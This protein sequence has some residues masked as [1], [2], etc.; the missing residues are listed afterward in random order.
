MSDADRKRPPI[1]RRFETPFRWEGVERQR[2][3]EGNSSFRDVSR[4]V[5]FN[6]E[7]G[8]ASQLRYFEIAP[9]GHTTLERHRHPHAVVV[10]R[11]RGRV[12]VGRA[13][14]D[15]RPYDLISVPPAAWHQ[16]QASDDEP[17]G[18]LCL[19]DRDRDRP[20]RPGPGDLAGLR[21]DPE[22]AA[23]IRT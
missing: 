19:V 1:L 7:H 5:L 6:G 2:Y 16:L 14:V 17:L 4:Q 10:L 13:I 8:E 3:K 20:E 9:G 22:V 12:L 11:G 15:V 21:S 23:F 18:F